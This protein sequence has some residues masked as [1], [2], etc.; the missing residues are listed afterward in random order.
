M[1][2]VPFEDQKR[3]RRRTLDRDQIVAAALDLLNEVGLDAL[4]M[5][6]L[7]SRLGVKAASLYRHVRDKQELIIHLA[8]AI[9]G[10]STIVD[11]GLP[12]RT[13]VKENA[14]EERRGLRQVRDGARLL[15]EAPPAGPK[16]L[17]RIDAMMA[18]ILASGCTAEDGVNAAYH[19][20]NLVVGFAADE[21]R[22]DEWG[23]REPGPR[24]EADRERI[25]AGMLDTERYPNLQ[26]LV[27]FSWGRNWEDTLQFGI[28]VFLDGF[29]KRIK[30][31][32][33]A[34]RLD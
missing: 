22:A 33:R 23:R 20:N 3:T 13:R 29:E 30:A 11:A 16:R 18:A 10:L 19:L 17:E 34:R 14:L 15:A 6:L 31:T 5:R 27:K 21:D 2:F 12:W 28:D 25:F 1:S 9:A 24:S 7:A 4:T 26:P 32:K 8:D